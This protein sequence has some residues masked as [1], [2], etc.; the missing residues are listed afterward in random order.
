MCGC[1][2]CA[3]LFLTVADCNALPDPANG[4][5]THTAG[6]TEGQTATYNCDTGY[7]LV[8]VSTR[9]CQANGEWSGSASTC[10]GMLYIRLLTI[11]V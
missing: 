6:T 5:V 9:T 10:Q 8:G 7:N 3:S 11:F 4:Q 2:S 1:C